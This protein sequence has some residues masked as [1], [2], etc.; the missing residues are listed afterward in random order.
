MFWKSKTIESTK[1][2]KPSH[3]SKCQPS[4]KCKP[5]HL[6]TPPARTSGLSFFTLG[7]RFAAVTTT[8]RVSLVLGT[9][10]QWLAQALPTTSVC[11]ASFS[12]PSKDITHRIQLHLKEAHGPGLREGIY[13]TEGSKVAF[14]QEHSYT[15]LLTGQVT[16]TDKKKKKPFNKINYLQ[17]ALGVFYKI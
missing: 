11:T 17:N 16:S 9:S 14:L 2:A 10:S 4:G 1:Q 3:Q 8:W 13:Y 7:S 15:K 5:N 6:R 12:H